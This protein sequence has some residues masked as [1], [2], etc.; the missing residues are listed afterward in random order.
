MSRS[1]LA[2]AREAATRD[3]TATP[4][5]SLFANPTKVGKLLA[6]AANDTMRDMMRRTTWRGLSSL[7]SSWVFATRRG[8]YA[9]PMP[10]D[11]LRFIPDTEQIA[12]V[13]LGLLGPASPACWASW[14]FGMAA[15]HSR[16]HWRVRNDAMFLEPIP[17]ATDLVVIEYISKYPVVGPVLE[18][19]V[20]FSGELPVWTAPFVPRDGAIFLTDDDLLTRRTEGTFDFDS[21]P[22]FDV[23]TWETSPMEALRR[24]D[25]QSLR[26]PRPQV[27]RP[28][29]T[30]DTDTPAFA[31]DHALS[32]GMTYRL[33]RGL[34]LDYGKCEQDYEDEIERVQMD[35]AGGAR[36]FGLRREMQYEQIPLGNGRWLV[37]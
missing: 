8:Q 3:N 30:A 11:F 21:P 29:F 34:A 36:A 35:D 25:P 10:P 26:D 16:A 19:D 32:L 33:R 1:I 9:Y 4:P 24:I 7:H 37:S 20:D 12:G 14:I 23:G 2:I 13:P 18:S 31:D 27:R 15:V 28:E 22:G 6:L 17:S 5:D